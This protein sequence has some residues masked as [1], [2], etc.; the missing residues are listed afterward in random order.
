MH[1]GTQ[2]VMQ[3]RVYWPHRDAT[4]YAEASFIA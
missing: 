3:R 2:H 1:N 4:I